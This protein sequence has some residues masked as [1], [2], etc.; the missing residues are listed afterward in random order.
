[1]NDDGEPS[2]TAGKPIYNQIIS[3][4]I[5]N[6]LIIVVRYFG[7][8]LLGTGG[9]INAYRSAAIDMLNNA[10]IIVRYVE[11]QY[12]LTFPYEKLNAVMKFLKDE[13][14][15]PQN[16]VYESNCVLLIGIRKSLSERLI[17][18]LGIIGGIHIE[19]LKMKPE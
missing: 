16:P 14:C 11:E 1:M 4:N 2:G 17:Q 12:R 3:N 5:T 6:A 9:L 8:T 19:S 18:K 10:S 15:V 13:N 7:G